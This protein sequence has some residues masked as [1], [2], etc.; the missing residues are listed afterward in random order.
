MTV[1]NI[2]IIG[3]GSRAKAHLD[4]IPRLADKYRLAAVC[5]L[6][7]ERVGQVAKE[8]G[9]N[10]YTNLEEMLD[11]EQLDVGLINV[12]PE[13]H[14]LIARCLAERKI[15]VLSET[16]I[17]LTLPCMDAMIETAKDNNVVLE[18]SENVPR[19]PLERLKQ[20]IVAGGVLGELESFYLSYRMGSYHGMSAIRAITGREA[21]EVTGEFLDEGEVLERATIT[22]EGGIRGT[23]ENKSSGPKFWEIH[24]TKGSLNAK[25]L[26][27]AELTEPLELM[28]E[29]SGEERDKVL[30]RTVVHTDPP[31]KWVNPHRHYGLPGADDVACADALLTLYDAVV[32]GA[33]AGYGGEQ[34]RKDMEW[35][36]AV[37]ESATLGG[38]P[39]KLPL[40]G[41]TE[42]EK[43]L[44]AEFARAHG[45]EMLELGPEHVGKRFSLAPGLRDFMYIGRLSKAQQ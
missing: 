7:P 20:K 30:E 34:A 13:G 3:V 43:R 42:H 5:G 27:L 12:Q 6:T 10:A 24:G 38:V 37:R 1:L 35:L 33:P 29:F 32:D 22:L 14:H 39:V 40:T 11:R 4:T 15:H 8:A 2:G 28:T 21:V 23:Y 17:A 16:P 36:I 19:W 25:D 45:V 31:M 26:C 9:V 44:H 41:M 18:V